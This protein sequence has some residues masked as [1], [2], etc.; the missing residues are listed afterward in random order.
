MLAGSVSLRANI[1]ILGYELQCALMTV[2][3]EIERLTKVLHFRM[4]RS[5]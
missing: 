3:L 4:K 1:C 2:Y 5:M